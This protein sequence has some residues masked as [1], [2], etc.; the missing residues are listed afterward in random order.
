MKEGE[1]ACSFDDINFAVIVVQSLSHVQLFMSPW[2]AAHQ[3]PL[4]STFYWTLLKLM[5]IEL[6]MLSNHHI[7]VAYCTPSD[8][9]QGQGVKWL[10][11][12]T[13]SMDMN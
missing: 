1:S 7:P 10:D 13:N 8:L 2:T 6:V 4:S 11:S 12:I 3:A 5:S 9:W